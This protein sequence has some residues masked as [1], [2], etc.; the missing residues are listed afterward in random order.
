VR[1]SILIIGTI[2]TLAAALP[3]DAQQTGSSFF[4]GVNPRTRV[5][6][7]IDTSKALKTMNINN[8]FRTPAQAKPFSLTSIF[9]TVHMPTW[10]P[11][12]ASTPVLSQKNNPF[13]PNPILG[14]NPF[15]QTPKK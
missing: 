4:T 14:K 6:V 7:P 10:P 3:V 11:K 5:D 8:A 2:V 13:Q 1:L 9:P 12:V 15:S